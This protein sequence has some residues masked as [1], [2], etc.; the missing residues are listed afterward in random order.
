[1]TSIR[2][3]LPQHLTSNSF[4]Y[5]ALSSKEKLRAKDLVKFLQLGVLV[6]CALRE[7]D[8][9][10]DMLV[11]LLEDRLLEY[12]ELTFA[13][14]LPRTVRRVHV[15]RTIAS[16]SEKQCWSRFRTR[17]TDLPRLFNAL[18]WNLVGTVRLGNRCQYTGEEIFLFGMNRLVYPGR[19]DD[20]CDMYGRDYSQWSRGF[21]YFIVFMMTN[22]K[23]LVM[24]NLR[25][26]QPHFHAFSESIRFKIIE[27]GG[28]PYQSIRCCSF[29]DCTVIGTSRPGAG[30][31]EPGVLAPRYNQFIQQA[32]YN[33]WKKFHGYKYQTLEGPNGMCLD[34]YGPMTFRHSDTELYRDSNLNDRM[35]QL[36]PYCVYGDGIYSVAS[37]TMSASDP[38][39]T[40]ARISNEWDYGV[41]ANLFAFCKYKR[42]LKMT[43]KNHSDYYTVA[44]ILRN[45]H[46]CMY[47]GLTASYYDH[48]APTLEDYLGV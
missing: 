38:I 11:V 5:Q 8:A 17:K 19:L 24:G 46:L 3:R 22:W 10:N 35:R 4:R 47:D 12:V 18:G 34:L 41:T 42:S 7:K 2:C 26:W 9:E 27:K 36:G 6:L 43:L 25:Y 29:V 1:M 21:T 32:A 23:Y 28:L 16:F 30:P 20:M 33:G 45:L 37:N 31:A 14:G 13:P 39:M 44:T 48:P 40:K 15:A